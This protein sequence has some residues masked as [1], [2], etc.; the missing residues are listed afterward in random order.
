M[1]F[2]EKDIKSIIQACEYYKFTFKDGAYDTIIKK[3][4]NYEEEYDCPG[5]WDP[6]LE[7]TCII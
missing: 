5:C 1:Q 6:T 4:H 7:H 2:N 3:L